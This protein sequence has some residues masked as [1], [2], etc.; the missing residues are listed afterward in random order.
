MRSDL[1][2]KIREIGFGHNV[3]GFD[4]PS[5]TGKKE[6]ANRF[7][8]DAKMKMELSIPSSDSEVLLRQAIRPLEENVS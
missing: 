6:F 8:P 1:Y 3:H 2:D 5:Y 4:Y 7:R